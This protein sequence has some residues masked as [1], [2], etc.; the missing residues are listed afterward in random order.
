MGTM[1]DKIFVDA[2]ILV[3]DKS[4]MPTLL[5]RCLCTKLTY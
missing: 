5:Q 4:M 1:G 3:A 2:N